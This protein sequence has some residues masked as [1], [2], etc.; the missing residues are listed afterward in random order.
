[1]YAHRSGSAR[2]SARDSAAQPR[3]A[4]PRSA[5]AGTTTL[6][7]LTS[8]CHDTKPGSRRVVTPRVF[9]STCKRLTSAGPSPV[10]TATTNSVADVASATK[11]LVPLRT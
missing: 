8:H 1:M 10:R 4:S 7:K 6:S 5:L 11:S 3:C 2:S 9:A